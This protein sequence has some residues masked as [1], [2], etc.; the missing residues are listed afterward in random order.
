MV[1]KKTADL[2][3][4]NIFTNFVLKEQLSDSSPLKGSKY[5]KQGYFWPITLVT[6]DL[7]HFK[8]AKLKKYITVLKSPINN[9]GIW[10][11]YK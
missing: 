8:F 10:N 2:D 9:E 3:D 6:N 11:K 4:P 5:C 7:S 1:Y